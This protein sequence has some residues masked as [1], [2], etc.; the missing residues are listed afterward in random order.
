M[1]VIN[2]MVIIEDCHLVNGKPLV[3]F[4][5]KFSGVILTRGRLLESMEDLVR[6]WR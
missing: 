1:S 2:I 5:E 3:T 4:R 6:T